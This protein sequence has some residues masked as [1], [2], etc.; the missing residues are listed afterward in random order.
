MQCHGGLSSSKAF[1]SHR[2]QQFL[3]NFKK[4]TLTLTCLI[5]LSIVPLPP[6]LFKWNDQLKEAEE[7][8]SIQFSFFFQPR[9][10]PNS[11]T[12]KFSDVPHTGDLNNL[13]ESK[14]SYLSDM[15]GNALPHDVGWRWL[16]VITVSNVSCYECREVIRFTFNTWM[17]RFPARGSKA[18][19]WEPASHSL[20]SSVTSTLIG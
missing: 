17:R 6:R 20:N 10:R 9:A 11:F 19:Q 8:I 1:N 5:R 18:R 4:E 15:D 3:I 2:T 16:L 12:V 13:Y 7:D 14:R